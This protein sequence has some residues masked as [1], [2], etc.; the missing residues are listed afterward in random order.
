MQILNSLQTI[1]NKFKTSMS[2]IISNHNAKKEA[3]RKQEY[4]LS[5]EA[6]DWAISFI[7]AAVVYFLI[8]PIF[9]H[10]TSPLVVVSSCSEKGFLDI[11]DILVIQGI[12]AKNVKAPTVNA[13]NLDFIVLNSSNQP[14]GLQ[15]FRNNNEAVKIAAGNQI[16]NLNKS[17]DI[18]VYNT[19]PFIGQVIHRA[20]LKIK[21]GDNYYLIT[22][23]D[24]NPIPDQ[25]G[26]NPTGSQYQCKTENP[27]ACISTLIDDKMIVGKKILFRIPWLGHVKLFFCDV[28]PFCEGHSNVGTGHVYK[29]SC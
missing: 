22:K 25:I 17:N 18:I 2:K 28:M 19:K 5:Q 9:L 20:F 29:L 24:A 10:T 15:N 8:L 3:A 16:V 11:G 13:N 12:S 7:V 1:W 23:G 27:S 26:F 4:N 14:Y 21:K 6:K